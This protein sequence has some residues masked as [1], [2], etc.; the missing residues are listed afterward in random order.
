MSLAGQIAPEASVRSARTLLAGS[1]FQLF[2]SLESTRPATSASRRSSPGITLALPV[3]SKW[4]TFAARSAYT[5]HLLRRT[6]L[7]GVRDVSPERSS[8][9]PVARRGCA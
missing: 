5:E 7:D 3:G 8:S 2:D 1:G 9:R 6:D 4:T